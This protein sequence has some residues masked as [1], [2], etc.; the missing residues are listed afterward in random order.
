VIVWYNE[1]HPHAFKF[2]S[3][4]WMINR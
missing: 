3:D 1:S 4:D 2:T